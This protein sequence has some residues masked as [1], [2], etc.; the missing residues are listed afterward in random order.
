MAKP[1]AIKF[2][3]SKSWKQCRESYLASKY[4]LCERCL[5]KGELVPAV[6]VHHKVYLNEENINDPNVALNHKN[7]ECVCQTCHQREHF[8][9]EAVRDDVYFDSN[10]NLMKKW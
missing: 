3:H 7:L 5:D 8:A 1:F 4:G 10:G 9:D 2:Y 6:I